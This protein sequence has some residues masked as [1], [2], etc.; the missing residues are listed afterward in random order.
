M[1]A[2]PTPKHAKESGHWY[3][4]NCQQVLDV[5]RASGKGM[6]RATL[7]DARKLDLAPGVTTILGC[8]DKPQLT[9]WKQRQAIMA[10]LTLPRQPDETEAA[11]MARVEEDMQAHAADAAAEGTRIHAA[12]QSWVQGES[13]DQAYAEH[14]AGVE[15]LLAPLGGGWVAERCV[16]NRRYGYGTKAD[17][18]SRHVLIDFKGK[19][20]DQS[21]LD[22]LQVYDDHAMQ[23]AS[24]AEAILDTDRDSRDIDCGILFVSRTH[25]GAASLRWVGE[26]HL[27]RGWE[28]FLGLN[29]Y[30][31]AK[32]GHRP[33]GDTNQ[34]PF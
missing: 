21:A 23:L 29:T 5:P 12:V 15:R 24:T 26:Q 32:T 10:A 27:M 2:L 11:W 34:V 17:L 28:M 14:V 31:Q 7:A 4:I 33:W 9:L 13:F 20:G 16:V 8:A 18:S 25:P 6:R 1:T 22:A 30:W 3:S 19:D